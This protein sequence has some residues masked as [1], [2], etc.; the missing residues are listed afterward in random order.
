M[1]DPVKIRYHLDPATAPAP[2]PIPGVV[3]RRV[4]AADHHP[5]ARLMLDAYRGT[6]DYEG[7]DLDDAVGEVGSWLGSDPLLAHSVVASMG[8][9][10]VSAVMVSVVEDEPFIGY[11]ISDPARKRRGLARL[12]VTTALASLAAAGHRRVVF[13]ITD[14]NVASERL[15]AGLGA[16]RV[17]SDG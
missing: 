16:V 8:G 4:V 15:F 17:G 3:T 2:T 13:Y 9:D 1:T 12:V 11:V 5:L 6:I 10:P 14:G 7:E